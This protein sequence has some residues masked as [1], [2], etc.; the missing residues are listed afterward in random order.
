MWRIIVWICICVYV[1]PS[2]NIDSACETERH[3]GGQREC[4]GK[5][6]TIKVPM[7]RVDKLK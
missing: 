4:E 7:K 2:T 6:N 1:K 3:G 5:N